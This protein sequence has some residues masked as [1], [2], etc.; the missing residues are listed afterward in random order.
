MAARSKGRVDGFD[1]GFTPSRKTLLNVG[2][3]RVFEL[4]QSSLLSARRAQEEK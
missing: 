1:E 3:F 4:R 2:G